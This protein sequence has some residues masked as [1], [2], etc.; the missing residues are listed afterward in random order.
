MITTIENL[1]EYIKINNLAEWQL[2]T[3]KQNDPNSYV[4]KSDN[5]QDRD[6]ELQRM[7]KV[8]NLGTYQRLYFSGRQEKAGTTGNYAE[9]VELSKVA[10]AP[11]FQ[12]VQTIGYTPDD[13]ERRIQQAIEHNNFE[14]ERKQFENE[15]KAL[16][17]ER[18]AF[19]EEKGGILG[20]L[21]EKAAPIVMPYLQSIGRLKQHPISQVAGVPHFEAEPIKVKTETDAETETET[22]AESPFTDEESDK[23]FSLMERFKKVEPDFLALIESVV[24]MAEQGDQMYTMAKGMLLKK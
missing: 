21:I 10:E 12:P 3:A 11:A 4:F 5:T 16:K 24:V 18:K 20:V 17:E 15:R 7:E 8:L 14:W 9:V 23:L 1:V 6:L 19:E 22:E 2:R 13:L